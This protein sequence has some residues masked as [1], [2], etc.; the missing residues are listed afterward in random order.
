MVK[1]REEI[2]RAV[3]EE[4]G[5]CLKEQEGETEERGSWE[6]TTETAQQH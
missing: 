2:R 3:L 4:R 5:L 6:E 1:R